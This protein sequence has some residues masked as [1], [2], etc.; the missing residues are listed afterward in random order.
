[1]FIW[2]YITLSIEALKMLVSKKDLNLTWHVKMVI[3][4][5][6]RL[7]CRRV[8]GPVFSGPVFVLCVFTTPKLKSLVRQIEFLLFA[9]RINNSRHY[10]LYYFKG[11]LLKNFLNGFFKDVF[12]LNYWSI[13]ICD[14]IADFLD[15]PQFSYSYDCIKKLNC[16]T[17]LFIWFWI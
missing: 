12:L 6:F 7:F 3:N 1:M 11:Y 9:V 2:Y 5:L 10:L 4:A 15:G 13:F 16:I 14:N 8:E 17:Y